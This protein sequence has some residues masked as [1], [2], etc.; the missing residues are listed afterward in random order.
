[1]DYLN[2]FI[3]FINWYIGELSLYDLFQVCGCDCIDI[4][5]NGKWNDRFCF[6]NNKF[7]CEKII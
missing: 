7:I 6:Y 3:V 2:M 1:M 4:I 5:G